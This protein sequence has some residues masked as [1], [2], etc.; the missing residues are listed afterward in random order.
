MN[1][2]LDALEHEL[3]AA[4]IE[5]VLAGDMERARVAQEMLRQVQEQRRASI[6]PPRPVRQPW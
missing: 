1:V 6:P 4:N 2:A 3:T 5:F